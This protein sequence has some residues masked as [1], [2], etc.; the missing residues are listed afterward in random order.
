MPE[1]FFEEN[2]GLITQL[3]NYDYLINKYIEY[4]GKDQVMILPY[5][6]LRSDPDSF[7]AQVEQRFGLQ[8]ADMDKSRKNESLNGYFLYK[9]RRLSALL[10]GLIQPLPYGVQRLLYGGYMGLLFYGKLQPLMRL[11]P[12]GN[13]ELS[14]PSTVLQQFKG[15]AEVLRHENLYQPYLKE[16]LL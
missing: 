6:M 1:A 10:H 2:A 11:F 4:F 7:T 8:K 5:E 16:Y 9:Y 12:S 3:Y 13:I 15:S 14:I